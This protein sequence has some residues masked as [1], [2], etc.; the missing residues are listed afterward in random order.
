MLGGVL[1]GGDPNVP[2][3]SSLVPRHRGH[4]A[5]RSDAEARIDN[6]TKAHYVACDAIASE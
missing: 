1:L 5:R 6:I 4:G 3:P 2:G